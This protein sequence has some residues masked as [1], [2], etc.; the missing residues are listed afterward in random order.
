M[1]LLQVGAGEED[2]GFFVDGPVTARGSGDELGEVVEVEGADVEVESV[3]VFGEIAFDPGGDAGGPG[4]GDDGLDG[5]LER[6]VGVGDLADVDG[7]DVGAGEFGVG[8]G[9]AGGGGD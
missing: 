1:L 4:L 6:G 8:L 3:P 2:E 5:L 9:Q 7:L